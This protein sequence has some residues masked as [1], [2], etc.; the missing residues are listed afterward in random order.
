MSWP[1]ATSIT[2]P[3]YMPIISLFRIFWPGRNSHFSWVWYVDAN[4]SLNRVKF[5]LHCLGTS[6][7]SSLFLQWTFSGILN[8]LASGVSGK[9]PKQNKTICKW[10]YRDSAVVFKKFF[11]IKCLFYIIKW[12]Q[13]WTDFGV[14][15]GRIG[16]W[17]WFSAGTAFNWPSWGAWLIAEPDLLAAQV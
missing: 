4:G 1:Q 10:A 17:G 11:G 8:F 6:A 5:I 14:R 16:Y 3:R 12:S 7:S 15:T 13:D 2:T 9:F